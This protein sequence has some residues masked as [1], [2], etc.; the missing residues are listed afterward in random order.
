MHLLCKG[1]LVLLDLVSDGQNTPR[2]SCT[3]K[4][5]AVLFSNSA[6]CL[7]LLLWCP[8]KQADHLPF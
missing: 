2:S 7:L 1:V 8:S 3:L 5:P 4:D 6:L